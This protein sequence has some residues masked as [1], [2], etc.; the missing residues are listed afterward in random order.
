MCASVLSHVLLF[1][2]PWT[3]AHKATLSLEF[4]RQKYLSRLPFPSPGDLPDPGIESE[5]QHWQAGS[6]PLSNLGSQDVYI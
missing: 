5:S 1:A 4:P 2:T 6:L 3:A